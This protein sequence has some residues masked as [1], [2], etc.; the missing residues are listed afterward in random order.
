[1]L[2]EK[3]QCQVIKEGKAEVKTTK[4]KDVKTIHWSRIQLIQGIR[5]KPQELEVKV[6]V[7]ITKNGRVD[8]N[9]RRYKVLSKNK[10]LIVVSSLRM[11]LMT[12]QVWHPNTLIFL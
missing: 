6:K 11:L 12:S 7:K 9:H 2:Q 1:M 8:V 3:L 10:K 5:E 4:E